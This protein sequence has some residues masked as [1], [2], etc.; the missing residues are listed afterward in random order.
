MDTEVKKE[1][2]YAIRVHSGFEQ[3]V[4]RSIAQVVESLNLKDKIFDVIV[5]VEKR[6][7][8]RGGKKVEK[9][10]KLFPGFVLVKIV[11]DNQT[12]YV[13]NNIEHVTGFVGSRT[14]AES[15]SEEEVKTIFERMKADSVKHDIEFNVGDFVKV[16]DGPFSD[17]DGKV[18]ELDANKG[19]V[20]VLIP[21]FGRE[22][23][24]KLDLYQ[25]RRI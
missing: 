1:E 23:P 22:T 2:W 24:I 25:I 12:W 4:S 6:I 8:I 20:T 11:L 9:E 18:S 7:K 3:V 16:T 21:M 19:Q 17:L 15:L 14:Q 5:P 10:E 13:I